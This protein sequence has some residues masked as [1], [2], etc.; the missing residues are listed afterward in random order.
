[1]RVAVSIVPVVCLS[2]AASLQCGGG[3]SKPAATP[4]AS[5]PANTHADAALGAPLPAV[6]ADHAADAP[7]ATGPTITANPDEVD[8]VLNNPGMG[9]ADFGYSPPP[10]QHPA[11]SVGYRRWSWAD[12]EPSEGQY[13]F[14]L[15]DDTI[16]RS[17]AKGEAL[18]FRIMPCY[19][20]SSPQWLLDKGVASVQA[21]DGV[22]PDH[23]NA[24][25]LQYHQKL[26][27]AF[28][29]RYAGSLDVDHVD[30]GSVGCW[31]EWNTACCD[32][33]VDTC[34][35]YFPT[36][37]NQRLIIDWYIQAF[38]GTPL[39]A[40]VAAPSYAESKGAGWRGD[41][42]GDY[43]MF[44]SS[45]CHMKDLYPTAAADPIIGVAWHHAPVQFESC[46]VM[47]DW[48]DR[49]FDI[50]LILQKGL[51][52][53][54]SVFNNKSSAVPAVWQAKV[55]EWLKHLG[56]RMVLTQVTHTSES[57][58][59]ESVAL[60]SSWRNKGVAPM[61]HPWPLAWR[62]RS[63]SDAVAAQWTSST[64][65]RTWLPGAHDAD[66]VGVV[67]AGVTPGVYALDVAILTEDAASA[68]VLLAIAG[69]RTDNWYPV[70]QVTIQP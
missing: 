68:H 33:N 29:R 65:L 6:D 21:T 37:A 12:L 31:G 32:T 27:E 16:Q 17:K 63:S 62:L 13:N 54:M 8:D 40:L 56:Y 5:D 1:M 69:R 42:F 45:W 49:G 20:T 28:G 47:Q 26:V 30:I 51:E 15:V 10:P 66:D 67:P 55:S 22:F 41:C 3:N 58:A 64:D 70:S 23:N 25:F 57:R 36:D 52:W 53:H 9:F 14:A 19:D 44:G 48:L 60:K 34:T 59:G 7:S 35:K 38:A 46:G 18:A 39:V 4:D 43:G 50:D 11:G 24:T 61:Y 2:I